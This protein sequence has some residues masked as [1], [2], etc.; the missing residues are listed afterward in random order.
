MKKMIALLMVVGL[1]VS[2]FSAIGCD[3]TSKTTVTKTTDVDTPGGDKEVTTEVTKK[4][5]TDDE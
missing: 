3:S 2:S 5:T 1:A 4:K